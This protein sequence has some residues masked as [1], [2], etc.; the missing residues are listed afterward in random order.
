MSYEELK[1]LTARH[2]RRDET[3][4]WQGISNSSFKKKLMRNLAIMIPMSILAIGLVVVFGLSKALKS[5]QEMSKLI[6]VSVITAVILFVTIIAASGNKVLYTITDR[7]MLIASG[8]VV[9]TLQ[10]K[11][12]SEAYIELSDDSE[13]FNV[14]IKLKSGFRES[15]KIEKVENAQEVCEILNNA[16]KS[17]I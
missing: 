6:F 9:N 11:D 1:A 17:M 8:K 15:L 2:M 7:R 10:F 13:L 12:I 4:L 14:V 16:I 3:L 5:E